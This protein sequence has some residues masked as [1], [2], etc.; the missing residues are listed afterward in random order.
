MDGDVQWEFSRAL[1][2]PLQLKVEYTL[3]LKVF[4]AELDI[5]FPRVLSTF[6]N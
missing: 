5:P 1:Q 2:M 6:P 3:F 4:F